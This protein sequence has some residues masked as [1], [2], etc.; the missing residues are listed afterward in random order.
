MEILLFLALAFTLLYWYV[1][2]QFGYFK[3]MGVPEDSASFPFGSDVSWKVWT[4]KESGLKSQ[5]DINGKFTNERFWGMYTFGKPI[6]VINDVELGKQILVK[7]ADHFVDRMPIGLSYADSRCEADK[8]FAMFLSNMSGDGWKRMRNMATPVFT[9]GKLKLMVP[10]IH[11]SALNMGEMLAESAKIGETLDAKLMFGKFALDAIATSG[12]GIESNSFKEPDNIFRVNVR[13]LTGDKEYA[14]ASAIPKAMF[15]FMAPKIA[16]SLGMSF[17]DKKITHFFIDVVRKTIENRRTTGVRRN[18][19]IDIF[20]DE[21]DKDHSKSGFS[22]EELETGLVATAILFFFAGFDTTST[23]LSIVVH[24]LVHH[25]EVQEKVR[26][27]IEEVIGDEE[28]TAEHLKDLKY[29]ENVIHESMRKYFKFGLNR[30]CTKPYKIP[31]SDF[32]VPKDL[33]LVVLPKEEDCFPNPDKFDPDNF[34]ESENLNKFGFIGFGQGPRNCIGMRYA[35]QTLKLAIIQTVRTFKLV[36][37]EQTTDEDKLFFAFAENGFRGG[38][39]F[40][41]ENLD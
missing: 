15:M 7:D 30:T 25:P 5:S 26:K 2:K 3:K 21:L 8:I 12:F 22:G 37:T 19:L 29:T 36:K 40:K 35:L 39:K 34:N 38:I 10:H 17:L 13:K 9:S 1:T 31:D 24:A 18:D 41:V 4:G 27:E 16:A 11:K 6:L 20:I 28:I 33:L 23:T 32:T 14:K